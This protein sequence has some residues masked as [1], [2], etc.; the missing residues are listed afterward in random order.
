[1]GDLNRLL[2]F[3]LEGLQHH[4]VIVVIGV[5]CVNEVIRDYEEKSPMA[6][7]TTAKQL[8]MRLLHE[9]PEEKPVLR[10]ACEQ[11]RKCE[12]H[13]GEF[14]GSWVLKEMAQQTGKP[15]WR[16]GLRRLAAFGLIEK[17]DTTRGGRR[18]YY[19]MQDRQGV[20]EALAE[21]Q[22]KQ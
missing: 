18:A 9:H 21:L 16:P 20:E 7:M 19:R 3:D 5:F 6:T 12:P 15:A 8:V 2:L 1:M 10:A 4:C 13:G 11:A 14:A 17:T 22:T